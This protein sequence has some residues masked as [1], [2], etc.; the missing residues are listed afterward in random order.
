MCG[1]VVLQHTH[2]KGSQFATCLA[3]ME[4]MSWSDLRPA[5][6]AA[7][8]PRLTWLMAGVL[9]AW[10]AHASIDAVRFV[11]AERD[12]MRKAATV[13][14]GKLAQDKMNESWV[15]K[16]SSTFSIYSYASTPDQSSQSGV[17]ECEGPKV[18]DWH[19]HGDETVYILEGYVRVDF[20]GETLELGPG[21]VAFFPAGSQATWHVPQ[22]VR[23]A[24]NITHPTR[25][26]RIVRSLIRT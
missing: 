23:K 3:M 26:Q 24:Y 17:W 18:F 25:L 9:V 13:Q 16:G 14:V 21:N 20:E 1:Q 2:V 22:R 19:F 11:R 4:H 12:A 6:W 10:C 8:W 5:R 15:R 7:R